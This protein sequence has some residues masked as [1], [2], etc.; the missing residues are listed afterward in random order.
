[1]HETLTDTITVQYS[2]SESG[3]TKTEGKLL[4]LGDVGEKL[5]SLCD[6]ENFC[7]S[8]THVAKILISFQP[9]FQWTSP[10]SFI[11]SPQVPGRFF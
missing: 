6:Q 7:Q 10:M 9:I 2:E 1:V 4:L 11:A 3:L 5:K 8:F